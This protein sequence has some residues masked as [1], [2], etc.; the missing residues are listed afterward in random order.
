MTASDSSRNALSPE[1]I[2]RQ[3]GFRAQGTVYYGLQ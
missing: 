2:L 1:V 3:S